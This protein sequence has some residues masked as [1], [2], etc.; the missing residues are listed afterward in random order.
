[1][2]FRAEFADNIGAVLT[3]EGDDGLGE[4]VMAL[5]DSITAFW[6]FVYA[7]LVAYLDEKPFDVVDC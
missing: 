1:M 4:F 6:R 5:V 2:Q 7:A 3:F